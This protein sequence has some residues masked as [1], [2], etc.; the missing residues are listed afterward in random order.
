MAK[1]KLKIERFISGYD[2]TIGEF[3]LINEANQPVFN[4]FTLEPAGSDETR[5]GLD[6]RIPQGL[7]NAKFE[8]SPRFTPK[9]SRKLPVLFNE[10]VSKDRRILIHIGN[11]GVDTL[12]CILLGDTWKPNFISNSTA[13]TNKVFD[14]LNDKDFEVEIINKGV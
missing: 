5:S 2:W 14:I 11:R 9:Y 6:K 12:G 3:R 4:G 13:T 10:F 1:F 8:Y 7:Y